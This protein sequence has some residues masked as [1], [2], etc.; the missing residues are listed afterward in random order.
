M[1]IYI[2]CYVWDL[3]MNK[4]VYIFKYNKLDIWFIYYRLYKV[5]IDKII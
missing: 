2:S 1:L 4:W 5:Y 3:L